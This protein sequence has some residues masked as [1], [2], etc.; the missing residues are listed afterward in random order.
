MAV[1]QPHPRNLA[2][3]SLSLQKELCKFGREQR[4]LCLGGGRRRRRRRESL[5]RRRRRGGGS[6]QLSED[7]GGGRENRGGKL[8][9]RDELRPNLETLCEGQLRE[10]LFRF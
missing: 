2:H 9:R 6:G 4:L 8:L 7:I 5:D 1:G 3:H 10:F